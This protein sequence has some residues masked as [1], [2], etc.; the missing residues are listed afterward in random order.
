MRAGR[1]VLDGTPASVFGQASWEELQSSN[2]D[3]PL[4]AKLGAQLGLGDTPTDDALLT[5]LAGAGGA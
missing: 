2:L 3:P 4:A 5:A 1:V